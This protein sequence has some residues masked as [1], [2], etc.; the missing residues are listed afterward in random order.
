MIP[1]ARAIPRSQV[2]ALRADHH[3]ASHNADL[4][5]KALLAQAAKVKKLLPA[6]NLDDIRQIPDIGAAL[7]YAEVRIDHRAAPSGAKQKLARLHQLRQLL[8]SA[9]QTLAHAGLLP[10]RKVREIHHGR[11]SYDAASDCV[12]LAGLFRRNAAAIKGKHP[13]TRAEIDEAARLGSELSALLVPGRAHSP[14]RSAAARQA[15]DDRNRLWTLLLQRYDELWRAGAYLFGKQAVD[16]HVPPLLA[17]VGR[18]KKAAQKKPDGAKAT[19]GARA[20]A[21]RAKAAGG[22]QAAS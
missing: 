16:Q 9:A 17:H 5:A 13:V 15:T 21:T 20:A 8:L 10:E 11:G 7:V 6:T 22:A 12:A 1:L 14:K 4:G 3:L 18:T 2:Q 19:N